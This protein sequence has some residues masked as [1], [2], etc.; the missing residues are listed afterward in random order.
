MTNIFSEELIRGIIIILVVAFI[1]F[2]KYKIFKLNKLLKAKELETKNKIESDDKKEKVDVVSKKEE[3]K[4][5]NS[6]KEKEVKKNSY[7][8]KCDKESGFKLERGPVLLSIKDFKEW[9][10]DGQEDVFSH[11]V[12]NDRNDF[13][14]W[15]EHV[16]EDKKLANKL[17]EAKTIEE[18]LKCF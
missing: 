16:F 2:F 18:A 5:T 1:V 17:K 7:D 4:K 9:L 14:S 13:A 3:P 11:H 6:L 12:T 10:E 8:I 15:I